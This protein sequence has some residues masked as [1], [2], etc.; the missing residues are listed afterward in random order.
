MK[1]ATRSTVWAALLGIVITTSAWAGGLYLYEVGGP[2]VGLA[3]AGYAARAQDAT[4]VFTNPAGMTRLTRPEVQLGVQPMY[5]NLK[6]SP[7]SNTTTSGSDGDGSDWLPTGSAFYVHPIGPDLRLGFGVAG[8]FGTSLKYEDDW[9]G[10]YYVKE[11][12][13]QGIS[14]LPTVAYRVNEWLSLGA[15]LTAMYG[16]FEDKVAVNNNP[17][18]L[19]T[20]PDGEL[21]LKDTDWGF[22]GN[23]GVL[24]ELS[25]GT[26]FGVTYLTQTK[27]NFKDSPSFSGITHPLMQAVADRLSKADLDLG[28]TAPQAV[29]ARAYHALTDRLAL[30][31]NVGW[32]DWS[33]FG[34]VD[35]SVSS[36]NVDKDA[37]VN[38]DYKDTWHVAL[39]AQYRV[40]DPWLLSCGAAYDSSMLD[41]DQR[42]P[43]L[44]VGA[45]WKFG[46]GAQYA[47]SPS[48]T[49][50]GAYELT[51]G[52]D[53]S[54]DVNQG[55]VAGRVSGDFNN[56]A[57]HFIAL[58][59][60]WKL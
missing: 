17:L 14:L 6:F 54:M 20:A 36:T 16:M 15:G 10:R 11:V 7:D 31:G 2:E 30:L 25:K 19:G 50:S 58:N 51:W 59:V 24:V 12:T 40:S 23:F 44:P 46:L 53:L 48:L 26:R 38:V 13:M 57:I 9:V 45:S 39:G 5:V 43:S 35:V 34:K 55:P 28:M 3:A 18:G 37:T 47:W 1:T 42:N 32:Q 8:Y 27:L 4:T 49:L 33:R 56:S 22:G 60:D 21:K 29:M 41:D 52:G